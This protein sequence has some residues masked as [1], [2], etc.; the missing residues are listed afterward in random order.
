[1]NISRSLLIEFGVQFFY[2]GGEVQST[3]GVKNMSQRLIEKSPKPSQG[4]PRWLKWAGLA[5]L[6]LILVLIVMHVTGN[7]LGGPGSHTMPFMQGAS[8]P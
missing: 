2:S 8:Q 4:V 5:F 1:M 7:S 3:N 6:V